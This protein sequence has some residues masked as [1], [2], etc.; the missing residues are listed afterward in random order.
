M[1]K[2][3]TDD[4]GVLYDAS[5]ARITPKLREWA[6]GKAPLGNVLTDKNLVGFAG[7]RRVRLEIVAESEWDDQGRPDTKVLARVFLAEPRCH[8]FFHDQSKLT[9]LASC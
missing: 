6:R 5:D 8:G 1:E 9:E 2:S 7:K 4:N 3:L